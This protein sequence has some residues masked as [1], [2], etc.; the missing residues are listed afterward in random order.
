MGLKKMLNRFLVV[1]GAG[2]IG[3]HVVLELLDNNFEVVVVDNL[4]TGFEFLIDK[5]AV[6]E[7]CDISNQNKISQIIDKYSCDGVIHL[8]ASSCVAESIINPLKFHQNNFIATS[9]LLEVLLSKKIS[10]FVFSSTAA[11]FGNV[12]KNQIPITENCPKNPINPYGSSKL[13]IE[14]DLINIANFNKNFRFVTL[15]YFNACGAD[16]NL[17]SG[18]CHENETHI[19]PLAIKTAL[20]QKSEFE[21]FGDDFDTFDGTCIRDY[22]HVSD[23]AKIHISAIKYLLN[24]GKSDSFNCGYKRGFSVKEII[25]AVEKNTKKKVQTKITTRREGDPDILIADNSHLIAK[26]GFK[27]Q[28]DDLSL[29]IKTAYDWELKKLSFYNKT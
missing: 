16:F 1:G 10:N 17:R 5:R 18:E 29:I 27:P 6:F 13:K 19:I 23:L 8:A 24:G 7:N 20:G 22:I 4:S 12:M 11:V 26:L 28:F 9:K 14:N 21:I 25:N 2:Y 15:R 3:S